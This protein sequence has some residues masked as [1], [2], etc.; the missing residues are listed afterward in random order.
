[1]NARQ[2]ARE[3]GTA[4]EF[5]LSRAQTRQS[6]IKHHNARWIGCFCQQTEQY[7]YSGQFV[8]GGQGA[9]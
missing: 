4:Q 5:G 7:R 1:M 2:P 3:N 8:S 9:G 6:A